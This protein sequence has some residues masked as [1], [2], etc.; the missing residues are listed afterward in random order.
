MPR[1]LHDERDGENESDLG[2]L[3]R[4]SDDERE[5]ERFRDRYR[6]TSVRAPQ[7]LLDS[8]E[9]GERVRE[10]LG[11]ASGTLLDHGLDG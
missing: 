4:A 3:Q 2:F 8:S 10:R 7:R 1:T 11:Y 6:G 9:V 5:L